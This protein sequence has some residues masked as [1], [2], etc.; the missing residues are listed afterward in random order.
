MENILVASD[1]SSNSKAAIRF[2]IQLQQQGKF[3]PTFLH[4][5]EILKP[6]KWSDKFFKDFELKEMESLQRKFK[7]FV[8]GL[9]EKAGVE[10][11]EINLLVKNTS[12]VTKSIMYNAEKGQFSYICIGNKG[13][14]NPLEI[15][16]STASAL[17]TASKVPVIS[18]PAKYKA[19]KITSICYASDL[20]NLDEE[21]KQVFKFTAPLASNVELLHFK[22][23]FDLY[24][25]QQQVDK[26]MKK[27]A[28]VKVSARFEQLNI[29]DSLV[30][31]LDKAMKKSKPSMLIMFTDQKRSFFER[32]FM[33]SKSSEFAQTAKIPLL[34]FSK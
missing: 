1:L 6:I 28:D 12:S 25:E 24:N 26:L 7:R 23:P 13:A 14:G 20:V 29:E 16:G 31:N 15:F 8:A 5:T 22:I 18:V 21:F 17:I 2:A 33:S 10:F 19:E 34:A 9:Y 27:L 30:E 11:Q 32:L 4:V 3:M